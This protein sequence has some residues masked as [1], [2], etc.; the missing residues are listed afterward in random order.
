MADSSKE[1]VARYHNADTSNS[2]VAERQAIFATNFMNILD[3][4][5]AEVDREED[6]E[7]A[8]DLDMNDDG[9]M[10]LLDSIGNIAEEKD[11]LEKE[12]K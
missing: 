9:K 12:L 5:K 6:T 7:V 4:N 8:V 10:E 11:R 3:F 1:S 2:A